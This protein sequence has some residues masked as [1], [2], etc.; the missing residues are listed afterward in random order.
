MSTDTAV[1][2]GKVRPRE[3]LPEDFGLTSE[4]I[5]TLREPVSLDD[6]WGN[7]WFWI[8]NAAVAAIGGAVVYESTQSIVQSALIVLFGFW[9][10]LLVVAILLVASFALFSA[11]WRRFQPDRKQYVDYARSLADYQARF[12]LWLRLQEF[13]WQTLDGRRFE[14]ELL[15]V[16]KRLGYDVRWTGASGDGGVDIVLLRSGHEI[17]V[18][19]KAYKKPVGPGPVRDLYGTMIHRNTGEAWLVA[20]S[21]FSR[22]A[23]EFASGKKIRLVGVTE[24]LQADKPLDS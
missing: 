10:Y 9:A 24:L 12:Y 6:V 8:A 18:Q 23:R 21:G 7:R 4:R 2:P 22:A 11:I 15:M 20:A 17:I 16:L 1:A 5:R 14:L 13:W 19:C 3:P